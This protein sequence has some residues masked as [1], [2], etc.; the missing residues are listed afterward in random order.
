MRLN[1][2]LVYFLTM[3]I[4]LAAS[5]PAAAQ[6]LSLPNIN[7]S[8]SEPQSVVLSLQILLLLTI[9]SLAPAF[10]ILTTSFTR[11]VIVLSFVR[12]GLSTQQVPPNQVII[13]LAIFLTAFIMAPSW[14]QVN[15]EALQPYLA[16]EIYADEAMQKALEP[17]RSFMFAQTRETDLSLFINMASLPRPQSPSDVPTHVLIPAFVISELKMAFQIGFLIYIPFLVIDMVVAS[18]LMSMGMLML[19]PVM[20]SLPFK[21]LLFVIVDGWHLVIQTLLKSF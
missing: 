12:S 21:L 6:P 8:E 16:G 1:S 4:F 10:I 19:P 20:I 5:I 18:T 9:L 14:I 17:I 2:C 7:L 15:Q 11:V 3:L 13:G